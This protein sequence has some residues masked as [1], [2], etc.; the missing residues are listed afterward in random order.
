M[1]AE[2]TKLNYTKI[3]LAAI[4]SVQKFLNFVN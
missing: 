3:A 4:S 2:M 1:V